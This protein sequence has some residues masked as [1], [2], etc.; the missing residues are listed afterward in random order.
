MVKAKQLEQASRQVYDSPDKTGVAMERHWL[1]LLSGAIS[2]VRAL[3][4]IALKALK[5]IIP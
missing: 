5:P 1:T 3:A 4:P 2:T